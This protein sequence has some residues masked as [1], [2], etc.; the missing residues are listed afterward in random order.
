M[1]GFIYALIAGVT[2]SLQGI[3][4]TRLSDKTGHWEANFIVALSA[5]IISTILMF[6][7]GKGNLK[8]L[9]T[10]NI[11]YLTG[12]LLGVAIIF[13]VMKS[14]GILGTTHAIGLILIAQLLSAA[15]IDYFGLFGAT[16]IAFNFYKLIGVA[17]MLVGIV[18][19]KYK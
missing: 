13:T 14:I 2:M 8:N 7:L 18:L 16:K 10:V 9:H 6:S 17:L 5:F 15:I 1:T 12:G 19:F 11:L 3:F 4:N